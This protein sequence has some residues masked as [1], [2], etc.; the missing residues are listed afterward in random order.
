M[1][2][3][4]LCCTYVCMCMHDAH[5]SIPYVNTNYLPSL[6]PPTHPPTHTHTHNAGPFCA[7][8]AVRN[9]LTD[10]LYIF[11]ARQKVASLRSEWINK[12]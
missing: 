8:F 11:H 4:K 12:M 5:S 3:H 9:S 6:S 10:V 2:V 7:Y 1:Y